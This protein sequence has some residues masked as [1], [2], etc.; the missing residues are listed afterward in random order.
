[1]SMYVTGLS[2]YNTEQSQYSAWVRGA[3]LLN[4]SRWI[5]LLSF[6]K[7]SYLIIIAEHI[8]KLQR[9]SMRNEMIYTRY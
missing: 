4:A 2:T 5:Y 3:T 9:V 1:M 8:S 7:F 6:H